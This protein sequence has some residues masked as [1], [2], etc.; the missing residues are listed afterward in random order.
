MTSL[1]PRRRPV[2]A[3]L[4]AC[5]LVGLAPLS[6][7]GDDAS[8]AAATTP[9]AA[10]SRAATE[11]PFAA[12][13]PWN[14][15]IDTADVATGSRAALQLSGVQRPIITTSTGEVRKGTAVS[16]PEGFVINTQRWTTLVVEGGAA[17]RLRC[18]QQPCGADADRVPATLRIPA[19]AKPDPRYDGWMTVVQGNAAYDLWRARRLSDGTISF[20]FARRWALNG[21]GV[22]EA[23]RPAV[24]GSGLPLFAG[25]LTAEELRR[26][27]IDHALAI[28]L[29]APATGK[30]V[31][32]ASATNGNG[33]E[34]AVPEGA[35]LRLRPGVR[36]S[37]RTPGGRTL[38]RQQERARDAILVALRR[39]GAI[40]VDRATV[41][42]FYARAGIAPEVLLGDELSALQLDD[43]D[44]V[45]ATTR[46]TTDQEAPS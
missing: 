38:S 5:A 9:A 20:A 15:R 40:V 27:Q 36:L 2:A 37:G 29:P 14:T 21:T 42:S 19:S 28:A 25:L 1:V 6:A 4:L 17:T 32:P 12:T 39:Y 33:P 45:R 22:G 31:A 7:C 30:A 8:T 43:F 3:P 26:G 13:S 10:A 24:R 46:V 16:K 35:R 44:V 23:D 34:A 18:R 41:P 11:R